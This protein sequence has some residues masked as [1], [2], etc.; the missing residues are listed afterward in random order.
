MEELRE[1]FDEWREAFESKRMRVKL[2]K[3]NFVVGGMEEETFD[4]KIDCCGE[5][6]TRVVSKSVLC[7]ACNK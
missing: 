5:R 6:G 3:T 4:S 2:V 7:T 1:N